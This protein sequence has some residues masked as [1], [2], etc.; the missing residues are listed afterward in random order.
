MNLLFWHR[1]NKTNG[2]NEAAIYCRI[3]IEG[4]RTDFTTNVFCSIGKFD[5]K[6]Q[7]VLNNDISNM[8][9]LNIRQKLNSIFLDLCN[10]N[11]KITPTVIKEYFTGKLSNKITV[12]E[13]IEKY[14]QYRQKLTSINEIENGTYIKSTFFSKSVL[15][16][17]SKTKLDKLYPTEITPKI[18]N[19]L[20]YWLQWKCR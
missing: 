18:A 1:K 8:M 16:F 7:I 11:I 13:L 10:K 12:I 20:Y 6:R 17:L 3:T 9:L 14:N 2:R 5:A 4:E 19:E 15:E